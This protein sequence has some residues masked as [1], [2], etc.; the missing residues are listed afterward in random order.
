M[1]LAEVLDAPDC[2]R[3]VARRHRAGLRP[4]PTPSPP[5]PPP[6]CARASPPA[7][8]STAKRST[9][10]S[11]W[12]TASPGT[13]PMRRLFRQLGAWADRLTAD[14]RFGEP[15]RALAGLLAC[16]YAGQLMGG[17]A[18]NQGETIRPSDFGL[19]G[20]DAWAASTPGGWADAVA[21]FGDQAAKSARRRVRGPSARPPHC[22]GHGPGRD[23]R[24]DPR[25]VP[26][27]RRGEGRPLCA[28][29]APERRADPDR[30]GGRAGRARRV[31]PDGGGGVRRL[32]PR[33]DGHVRRLRGAERA[34]T[35]ASAR[36]A[37]GP[38]SRRN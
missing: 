24:D 4:P 12:S 2:A 5:R 23:L 31:R 18:M 34:A 38:R 29:L 25:P 36:S 15:E 8:K 7:A 26:R 27:L 28:R 37:R 35:S 21:P 16:E 32:G 30:T 17:I 10:S 9:A 14:G 3:P 20:A 13:P 1:S 22:R 6:R 11:T 19:D 33:Q